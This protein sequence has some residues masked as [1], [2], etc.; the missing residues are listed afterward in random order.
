MS[1]NGEVRLTRDMMATRFYTELLRQLRPYCSRPATTDDYQLAVE[2]AQNFTVQFAKRN[3]YYCMQHIP[4]MV[5]DT[6]VM[7]L[8]EDPIVVITTR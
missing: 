3:R 2:T 1:R 5:S 4:T 8:P 7:I 6:I